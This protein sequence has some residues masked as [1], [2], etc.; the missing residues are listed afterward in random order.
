[1][2]NGHWFEPHLGDPKV[3]KLPLEILFGSQIPRGAWPANAEGYDLTNPLK[4][5]ELRVVSCW[6]RIVAMLPETHMPC[7]Q[8]LVPRVS[9]LASNCRDLD[10]NCCQIDNRSAARSQPMIALDIL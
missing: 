1:M 8:K 4:H 10:T 3:E 5:E 2:L 7:W 9:Q 6:A